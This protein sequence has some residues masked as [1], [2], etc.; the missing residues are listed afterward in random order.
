MRQLPCLLLLIAALLLSV[1][2]APALGQQTW[3]TLPGEFAFRTMK[4][5]YL[6]ALSGGGRATDPVVATVATRADAWEKFR[7]E[8]MDPPAPHDNA[9]RTSSGNYLTAV[10]G[11]GRT[12]DVLHTDATQARAWEQFRVHDLS[13]T[14]P[15]YFALQTINNHYVT[16]V[17]EGGKYENAIHTDA[18]QPRAWEQF[19][20]VKCGDLGD[21]R[22]YIILAPGDLALNASKGGGIAENDIA[23]FLLPLARDESRFTFIRQQDG[24]YALRTAN[25]INYLTALGG[26]GLVQKYSSADC[27]GPAGA[28]L[29]SWSNIFHTDATQVQ[30]WEK[31]RLIDQGDCKYAIQTVSGFFVGVFQHPEGGTLITTRRSGPVTDTEKF[32]LVPYGLASPPVLQ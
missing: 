1:A 19:R 12:S 4:G 17:G 25:G 11:G 20:I 18:T 6:S 29:E 8:V 31:F 15:T 30:A 7:I 27:P 10:D 21:G 13:L 2:P 9:F 32:Q 26:G 23:T 22:Q 16:A 24:T 14:A 5:F 28:C 3:D